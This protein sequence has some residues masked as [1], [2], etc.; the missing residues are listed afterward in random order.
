MRNLRVM[1]AALLCAALMCAWSGVAAAWADDKNKSYEVSV[2]AIRATK[3]NSTISPELK[4]IAKSLKQRFNYAG[5]KLETKKNGKAAK[6]KTF[7]AILTSGYKA[8]V[9]P[10]ERKG[11]RVKLRIEITKKA[12]KKEKKLTS[13]TVTI[14]SGQFLPVGGW[15][16][17]TKS[18]D[19]L[20]VAVSGK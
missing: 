1:N 5:F 8:K 12:G 7:N 4:P 3:S 6:G 11:D 18:S 2:Y 16:I 17:D 13:T 9:T 10:L 19:V 15:K 14:N 20:I